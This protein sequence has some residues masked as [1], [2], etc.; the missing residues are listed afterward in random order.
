M[1]TMSLLRMCQTMSMFYELAT[2]PQEVEYKDKESFARMLKWLH[3]EDF[4]KFDDEE[5]FET[6][7][8][9]ES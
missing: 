9:N 8:A 6:E 1:I 7:E 3:E 5:D 2:N 4:D